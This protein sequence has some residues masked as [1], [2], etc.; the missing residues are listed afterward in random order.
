V[1]RLFWFAIV[2]SR[3]AYRK[4]HL[5]AIGSEDPDPVPSYCLT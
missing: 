3:A 4:L 2:L 1:L 5:L